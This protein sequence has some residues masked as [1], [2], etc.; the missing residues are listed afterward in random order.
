MGDA[1][2]ELKL[3]KKAPQW[4]FFHVSSK[5]FNQT[6]LYANQPKDLNQTIKHKKTTV[7]TVVFIDD[8][9]LSSKVLLRYCKFGTPGESRTPDLLVRSQTLYPTE[10]RAHYQSC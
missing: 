3:L 4:C 6:D 10:L 5:A 9:D 2:N 7:L 1:L 8:A